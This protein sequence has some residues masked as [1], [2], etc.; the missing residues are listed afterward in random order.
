M[1]H[2]QRL[3][4]LEQQLPATL[5]RAERCAHCAAENRH[6]RMIDVFRAHQIHPPWCPP[7]IRATVPDT[8][9]CACDGCL[10]VIRDRCEVW[11]RSRAERGRVS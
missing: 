3:D 1:G 8:S 10:S 6:R 5:D 7:E 4:R 2:N 11:D 9:G